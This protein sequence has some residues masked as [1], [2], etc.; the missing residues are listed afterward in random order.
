M[1]TRMLIFGVGLRP[2]GSPECSVLDGP[3][4]R[5]A[6]RHSSEQIPLKGRRGG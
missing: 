6:T 3:V 2:V 4:L 5:P 1:S